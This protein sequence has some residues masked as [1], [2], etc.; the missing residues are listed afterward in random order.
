MLTEERV[1]GGSE[2]KIVA[3]FIEMEVNNYD[4]TV[5][6]K[7]PYEKIP[8]SEEITGEN[9]G[10]EDLD[11]DG[12]YTGR[13]T[14]DKTC[15]YKLEKHKQYTIKMDY[16]YEFYNLWKSMEEKVDGSHVKEVNLL[17]SPAALL[18]QMISAWYVTLRNIAIIALMSVLVY[19]GIRITLTSISSEKAKYKQMLGDWIIAI[20]LVFLMHYLM[21]F[22]VAVN[23][24]IIEAISSITISG[25]YDEKDLKTQEE[26]KLGNANK[27]VEVE[28]NKKYKKIE[29][30]VGD[31]KYSAEETST[32]VHLFAIKDNDQV[33][34]A[35]KILVSDKGQESTF[36]NRF[37]NADKEDS[38][39]FWPANDFMTQARLL[40]QDVGDN[41][42]QESVS[43]AGYNII[44][45]VLV[46]YTIIFCFI[47]LK[48]VAYM[49]FLTIIAPLVAITYPIDKAN[50][51]KAQAFNLWFREYIFNLL[52]QPM[53]LIL[54]SVLVSSAIK[55]ASKNI[56]YAV[57]AIG[58]LMPAEKLLRSF[59]GFEKAQTAGTFGAGAVAG[60]GLMM[61]G[62]NKLMHPKS[63][64]SEKLKSEESDKEGKNPKI[65]EKDFSDKEALLGE[66]NGNSKISKEERENKLALAREEKERA[67]K[68][69][70]NAETRGDKKQYIKLKRESNKNIRKYKKPN[71]RALK[72]EQRKKLGK[73]GKIRAGF[74][75]KGKRL[76]KR[77][78]AK[79]GLVKG[80]L[81]TA[82]GIGTA[83]TVA[84]AG[85]IIGIASGDPTKAA[86]YMVTGAAGGYAA[87][88]A[89]MNAVT[90]A[91]TIPGAMDAMTEGHKEKKEK[92]KFM[93]NEENLS[94]IEEKFNVDRKE[95][96]KIMKEDFGEYYDAGIKNMKSAMAT[97]DLEK[98]LGN[99]QQAITTALYNDKVLEGR[100]TRNMPKEK[101]KEHQDRMASKLKENGSQNPQEDTNKIFKNLDRYNKLKE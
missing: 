54:Y 77:Y 52:M 12:N 50:D 53:H 92:R 4:S 57:V 83:A 41:V 73:P 20:C 17:V 100:D 67:K 99:R 86:Q 32:G 94:K 95:A 47:Y 37:T 7:E 14:M 9:N 85:G 30:K 98:E 87:G 39:L 48:R 76:I 72:A 46:I 43:K 49:A 13:Y 1:S 6:K 62:L 91:V 74:E 42:V 36:A 15:E 16:H 81:R 5:S 31:N 90:N 26:T 60:T 28:V 25:L 21:S 63:S 56:F 19:I 89:G 68:G 44:Y 22:S 3:S 27:T 75:N 64:S 11:N 59:F 45:V 35:Y 29:D 38:I 84:T 65:R 80:T 101:R 88:K 82:A 40:G 66:T 51:G 93:K 55:F 70:K 69:L 8:D 78:K 23:E 71:S 10:Y 61:A 96:K 24:K 79:G 34:Y 18:R 2:D 97:Y 33:K 58:F